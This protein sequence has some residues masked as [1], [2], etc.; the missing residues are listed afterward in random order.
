VDSTLLA[1]CGLP[2]SAVQR[3]SKDIARGVPAVAFPSLASAA[4]S[5][6]GADSAA[7]AAGDAL[8]PLDASMPPLAKDLVPPRAVMGAVPKKDAALRFSKAHEAWYLL[9]TATGDVECRSGTPPSVH[10]VVEQVRGRKKHLTHVRGLEALNLPLDPLMKQ[11]K[12]LFACAATTQVIPAAPTHTEV[13]IQ[14]DHGE[15]VVDF[16]VSHYG[17]PRRLVELK[18]GAAKKSGG[19]GSGPGKT[20]AGGKTKKR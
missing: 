5:A 18:G 1:A 10:I 12:K 17:V 19:G 4:A 6:A 14:G 15:G 9:T 16:L 11:S 20:G 7:A 13:L 2:A 8:S 3:V